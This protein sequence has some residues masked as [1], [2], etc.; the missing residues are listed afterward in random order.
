MRVS[1]SILVILVPSL[2]FGWGGKPTEMGLAIIAGAIAACFINI[3]KIQRFKGAGFEAEMR[4]TIEEAY[5][6]VDT[7]KEITKPLII[8]T[9][10]NLTYGGRYGGI[11]IDEKHKMKTELNNIAQKLSIL[12][13]D[14]KDAVDTFHKYHALDYISDIEREVYNNNDTDVE[15]R[16]RLSELKNYNSDKLPN[17]NEL[18]RV[19]T[20]E[21]I[22]SS[23]ND[24]I[25]DYEYYLKYK[26]IR[27]DDL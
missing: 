18:R 23:I 6:T 12:D 9:I 3:D 17:A 19:F 13:N 16:K 22:P 4:R 21:V 24:I 15:I 20:G 2:Y 10:K 11:G 7:L 25:D 1:F 5:A 27:N 14:I 8:S 26:R